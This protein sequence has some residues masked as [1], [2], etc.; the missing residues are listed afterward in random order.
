[1]NT[2]AHSAETPRIMVPSDPPPPSPC[3]IPH[4][5]FTSTAR[6]LHFRI[7]I[8]FLNARCISSI[9]LVR[10]TWTCHSCAQLLPNSMHDAWCRNVEIMLRV[11]KL[12]N[13]KSDNKMELLSLLRSKGYEM[14]PSL[15][16]AHY[17]YCIIYTQLMTTSTNINFLIL[18]HQ[19]RH[20]AEKYQTT[21]IY[22]LV[23]HTL[24]R[25]QISSRKYI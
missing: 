2:E 7:N 1:M 13:I 21:T 14:T 23:N 10:T 8:F 20:Q 15:T 24:K 25:C 3:P 6:I 9:K 12:I 22:G 17:N 19:A 18:N 4:S 11:T 5:R 16:Y